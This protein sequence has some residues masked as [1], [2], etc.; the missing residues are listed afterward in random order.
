MSN[1]RDER[2][3][4]TS[5]DLLRAAECSQ[6]WLVKKMKGE[7]GETL[8]SCSL[9]SRAKLRGEMG[10]GRGAN[11]DC[12]SGQMTFSSDTHSVNGQNEQHYDT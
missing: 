5:L 11:H 1:G 4:V 9:L 12:H 8:C 3:L 2:G 10:V 6:P 7:E